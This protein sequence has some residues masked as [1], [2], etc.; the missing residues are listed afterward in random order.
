MRKY[1]LLF[2]LFILV[3]MIITSCYSE[4]I[5]Y[6]EVR[7]NVENATVSLDGENRGV[8]SD[9]LCTIPVLSENK[10]VHHELMISKEGY[11]SYN[12]TIIRAPK[13]EKTIVLRGTLKKIP[14]PQY[15]SLSIAVTPPVGIITLD[16]TVRGSIDQ[17]GVKVLR[18]VPKGGR[19]LN[20]HYDGYKDVN[21]RVYIEPNLETTV[22]YTLIPITNGSIEINS[23]PDGAQIALNG[24]IVGNTPLF[25]PEIASG[26]YNIRIIKPDY[27]IWNGHATVTPGIK[28]DVSASLQQET[29]VEIKDTEIMPA[30]NETDFIPEPTQK[31]AGTPFVIL[32]GIIIALAAV[33][34]KK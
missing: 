8:I 11:E 15:G 19:H 27:Q 30:E 24:E 26:P 14:L 33:S 25:I 16:G 18:D 23:V 2:C 20:I 7:A 17:S 29:A 9:G 31:A 10:P 34:I 1:Q 12:E 4:E 22:R 5:G 13:P 21:E 28:T 32:T 3:C 6:Y